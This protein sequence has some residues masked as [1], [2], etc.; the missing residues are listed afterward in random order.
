MQ[1]KQ[2]SFNHYRQLM[3]EKDDEEEEE[4]ATAFNEV[5]C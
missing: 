4:A 1:M 3:H 2:T 5:A